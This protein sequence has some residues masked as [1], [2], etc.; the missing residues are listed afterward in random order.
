VKISVRKMAFGK[1]LDITLPLVGYFNIGYQSGINRQ[2][3]IHF[4]GRYRL[5]FERLRRGN[6]LRLQLN[7]FGRTIWEIG[8]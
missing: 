1:I 2:V 6:K 8:N 4:A 3:F 7:K 5:S